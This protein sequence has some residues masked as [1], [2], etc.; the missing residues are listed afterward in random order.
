MQELKFLDLPDDLLPWQ[1]REVERLRSQMVNPDHAYDDDGVMRWRSNDAAIPPSV[2]K[3][4]HVRCPSRQQRAYDEETQAFLAEYRERMK[5]YVPTE[6]E[7]AEMRAAFGPGET[8]VN[9]ITG[10]KFRT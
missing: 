8:V 10:Q 6:E 7:Q 2:Y 5:D 9:V 3:D 4:A 1:L